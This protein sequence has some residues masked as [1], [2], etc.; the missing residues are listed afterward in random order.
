MKAQSKVVKYEL[1]FS[2]TQIKEKV[3]RFMTTYN[4]TSAVQEEARQRSYSQENVM[5]DLLETKTLASHAM[6]LSQ[7][8]YNRYEEEGDETESEHDEEEQER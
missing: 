3:L 2:A 1:G 5:G 7:Y 6:P 8:V 4:P